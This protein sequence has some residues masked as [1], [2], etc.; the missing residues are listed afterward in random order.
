LIKTLLIAAL[1]P[2]V[3]SLEDLTASRLVALNHGSIKAP[4]PGT[5]ASQA[6]AKLRNW[7]SQLTQIQVGRQADPSVR[8]ALESVDAI[9]ILR[10]ARE[11][12]NDGARTRVLRQALFDALGLGEPAL[13]VE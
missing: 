2:H 6:T 9:E 5:E 11:L 1:V 4:I 12:D 3:R 10:R 7:S 13:E 8:V